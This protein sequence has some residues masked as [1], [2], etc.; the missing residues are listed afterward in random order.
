MYLQDGNAPDIVAVRHLSLFT[1]CRCLP[2]AAYSSFK[3][4]TKN[5]TDTR[6]E[7][8]GEHYRSLKLQFIHGA[9]HCNAA[10]LG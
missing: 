1:T 7:Q 4:S 10:K 8:T 5:N 3:V 2:L 9:P 6:R